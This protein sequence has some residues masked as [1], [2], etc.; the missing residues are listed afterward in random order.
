MRVDKMRI[1]VRYH[2]IEIELSEEGALKSERQA[3]IRWE[4][5]KKHIQETIIVMTEQVMKL[6]S[7]LDN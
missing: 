4:G 6:R 1:R 5:E 3:S 2:E 7:N